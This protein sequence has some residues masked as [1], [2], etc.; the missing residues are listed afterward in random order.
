MMIIY[1]ACRRDLDKYVHKLDL[2][3][4]SPSDYTLM[5]SGMK[6]TYDLE[7]VKSFIENYGRKDGT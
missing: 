3:V 7:K 1:Y 5:V 6:K 4:D 2:S